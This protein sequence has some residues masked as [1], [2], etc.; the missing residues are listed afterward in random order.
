MILKAYLDSVDEKW[1]TSSQRRFI[2]NKINDNYRNG[3]T[4]LTETL[5]NHEVDKSAPKGDRNLYITEWNMIS[6]LKVKETPISLILKLKDAALALKITNVCEK[7]VVSIEKGDVGVASSILKQE[8]FLLETG[9]KEKPVS[10][11]TCFDNRKKLILDKRANPSKYAGIRTGFNKF[12]IMTGGLFPAEMTLFSAITGVGKSTIMKVIEANAIKQGKNCLHV[13]NEES[14]LQ[15]ET[16]FDTLFSGIPYL[17]F[18]RGTIGDSDMKHWEE[19]MNE[20]KN[21][22]LGKIVIKELPPYTSIVDIEKTFVEL[23]QKGTKIDIVII[24]YMDHLMSVKKAWS[25]NDEQ[26]QISADCK[27]LA[28]QLNVHVM[29]ATQ[30]ATIVEEKTEKGKDFGKMNVYGS[31]RKIHEANTFVGIIERGRLLNQKKELSDRKANEDCDVTWKL[32]V[33]KNRDG[34]SFSFYGIFRVRTGRVEEKND[35]VNS[36]QQAQLEKP[37]EDRDNENKTKKKL[38]SSKKKIS[39]IAEKNIANNE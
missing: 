25:E 24:D 31:K 12:D 37:E 29:T 38:V 6:K 4:L 35:T 21:P 36:M 3:K 8:S 14:Q 20:L 23:E 34:P 27:S 22:L 2:L 30:A 32:H 19:K 11:L 5:F 10:I 16:K 26:G 1:F 13:T 39:E 17:N 7:A 15:V 9:Y 33:L 18:K 28:V